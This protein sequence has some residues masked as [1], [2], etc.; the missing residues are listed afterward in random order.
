[1]PADVPLDISTAETAQALADHSAVVVDV[2]EDAERAEGHIAGT[3]HVALGS[4]AEQ[5]E[6]LPRDRA[7]IFYCHSGSRSA[8]AAQAF[9]AAGYDARS[10]AGGLLAWDA[11]GRALSPEGAHVAGH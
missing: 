2:R 7:V 1:M 9:R 11:E 10:M 6:T 3:R 8:M 4:L 5:A